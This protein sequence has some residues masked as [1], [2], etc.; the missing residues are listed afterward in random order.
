MRG[1]KQFWSQH[2]RVW[3]TDRKQDTRILSGSERVHWL[4]Y[5]APRDVLAV[6]R[7]LPAAFQIIWQRSYSC[8]NG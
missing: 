1:L 4:P 8:G 6:L 2:E 3:V 7:N 5:Q